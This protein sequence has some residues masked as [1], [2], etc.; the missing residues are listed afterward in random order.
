MDK[1]IAI[2]YLQRQ[3]TSGEALL[4]AIT[5]NPK[6]GEPRNER[7]IFIKLKQHIRNFLRGDTEK[8]VVIVPG[9]RGLRKTTSLAQLYM[10]LKTSFGGRINLL[11]FPLDEAMDK[12]ANLTMLLDAYEELIGGSYESLQ[13]Y[14]VIFIDEI[15]SDPE[16]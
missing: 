7:R 14:T 5:L 16:W 15:Q 12:V 6:T 8:Q 11:Y 13:K 1:D 10:A 9:L 3:L 4:E 2:R